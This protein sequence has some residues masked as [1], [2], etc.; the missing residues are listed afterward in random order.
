MRQATIA[1]TALV[2]VGGLASSIVAAD[3]N[4]ALLQG[5]DLVRKGRKPEALDVFR[6]ITTDDPSNLEAWNER[7][8]LEA[9]TGDLNSARIS[10]EKAFSA[11]ADIAVLARNLEKVR[12]RQARLAYDSAFGTPSSLPPL[13]LDAAVDDRSLD[14]ARELDSLR[15][16]LVGAQEEIRKSTPLRDSLQRRDQELARLR[17]SNQIAA[18]DTRPPASL[19]VSQPDE[20][21]KPAK[22]NPPQSNPPADS[23]KPDPVAALKAWAKAWSR[24]DV[25]AYLGC[26]S[27]GYHPAGTTHKEW[28]DR[29][30]ERIGA[31]KW[32]LVEVGSPT[33]VVSQPGHTEIV[34]RQSYQTET[35]KLASRKRISLELQEGEW[36]IVAESEAR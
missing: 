2:L 35:G 4:H 20:V 10:L 30:R 3:S 31:P 11:R 1:W 27:A 7:A 22:V 8:A 16:A 29:R 23:R 25:A 17:S 5:I 6:R 13:Q 24:Q 19:P 9:A 26:Y 28:E 12:S 21:A 14:R 15:T 32:I 33:V 36:K 34:Y 18:A